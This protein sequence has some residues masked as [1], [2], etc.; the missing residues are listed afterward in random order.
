MSRLD[1]SPHGRAYIAHL[2]A[3]T[4]GKGARDS[5]KYGTSRASTRSFFVHHVQRISCAACLGESRSIQKAITNRKREHMARAT[6]TAAGGS[7]H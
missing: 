3:R 1:I 7:P 2:Q 4:R 5:T 6:D